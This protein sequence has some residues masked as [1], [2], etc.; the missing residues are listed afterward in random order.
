MQKVVKL[1]SVG[2]VKE[3]RDTRKYYTANFSNPLNPFGKTVSRNFWQQKN[4]AGEPVWRGADPAQVKPFIGRTIPG[5]FENR[6]VVP[7]SIQI[8]GQP[9]R[10]A[11]TYP[12]VVLDGENIESVYKSVGHP[13]AEENTVVTQPEV[14]VDAVIS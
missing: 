11:N 14:I 9:D 2:E 7:Y 8:A 1:E 10:T 4:A 3:A 12:T 13:L 6:N 5:T